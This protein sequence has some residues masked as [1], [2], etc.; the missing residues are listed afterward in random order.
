MS[1]TRAFA[2][3]TP[4]QE[5]ASITTATKEPATEPLERGIWSQIF[6]IFLLLCCD[7][8]ILWGIVWTMG[9]IITI[10]AAEGE[11]EVLSNRRPVCI[12][13][14]NRWTLAWLVIKFKQAIWPCD[15]ARTGKLLTT[16]SR[17]S[18]PV[19]VLSLFLIKLIPGLERWGNSL[20]YS[21]AFVLP[22]S[23]VAEFIGSLLA[24]TLIAGFVS[25]RSR[26]SPL[27]FR[28]ALLEDWLS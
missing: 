13:D 15:T 2:F 28:F 26:E 6:L 10:L 8:V 27:L 21:V 9:K 25:W 14:N 24:W 11:N 20:G 1:T 7:L 17:A 3:P 12:A 23:V 19:F 18:A 5:Y 22:G 16:L 4:V